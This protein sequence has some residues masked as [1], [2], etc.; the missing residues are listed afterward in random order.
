MPSSSHC[1]FTFS[2]RVRCRTSR[3]LTVWLVAG[4]RGGDDEVPGVEVAA[5]DAGVAADVRQ[6]HFLQDLVL[7]LLVAAWRPP[8]AACPRRTGGRAARAARSRRTAYSTTD[9]RLQDEAVARREL[10][11]GQLDAMAADLDGRDGL[12]VG[13]DVIGAVGHGLLLHAAVAGRHDVTSLAGL[14][15]Q[16]ARVLA[17]L[18]GA[19][20]DLFQRHLDGRYFLPR[21]DVGLRR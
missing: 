4:R 6:D 12:D 11:V 16:V 1:G 17:D 5:L 8:G 21:V 20:A 15:R 3:L 14:A 18:R 7:L 10:N 2:S 13:I 19:D 9:V